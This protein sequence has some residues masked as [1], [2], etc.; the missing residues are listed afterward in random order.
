MI[1]SMLTMLQKKLKEPFTIIPLLNSRTPSLVFCID[2]MNSCFKIIIQS[3]E[4][5]RILIQNL[6][7][8]WFVDYLKI[9]SA[10]TLCPIS[11]CPMKDKLLHH[12]TIFS[13]IIRDA[14]PVIFPKSRR[15]IDHFYNRN[16]VMIDDGVVHLVYIHPVIGYRSIG[17]PLN[18]DVHIV[19]CWG[20]RI[21]II[22]S[23]FEFII[24]ALT[25]KRHDIMQAHVLLM[26]RI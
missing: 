16:H 23:T 25:V 8:F 1:Y 6:I 11:F 20:K 26:A 10:N 4:V 5:F 9:P 17:I 3:H 21:P 24:V 12:F 19:L 13:I 22:R 2:A 7:L 14:F 15:H 18:D